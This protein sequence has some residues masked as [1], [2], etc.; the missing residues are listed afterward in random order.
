[1]N[2]HF[3]VTQECN[4]LEGS[5]IGSGVRGERGPKSP[6]SSTGTS[7]VGSIGGGVGARAGLANIRDVSSNFDPGP[8]NDAAN[9]ETHVAM[10]PKNAKT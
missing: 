8:S 4:H 1:L 2:S 6:E 9:L 3:H 7:R 10:W 5:G